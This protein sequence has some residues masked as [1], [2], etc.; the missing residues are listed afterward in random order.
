LHVFKKINQNLLN[1]GDLKTIE[2]ENNSVL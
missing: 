2:L 1:L